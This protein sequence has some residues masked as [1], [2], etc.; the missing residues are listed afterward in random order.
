MSYTDP[1]ILKD[2]QN[3]D[4]RQRWASN[5]IKMVR[6]LLPPPYFARQIYFA[7]NGSG[8]HGQKLLA[9]ILKDLLVQKQFPPHIFMWNDQ[10]FS[11]NFMRVINKFPSNNPIVLPDPQ[12]I[13]QCAFENVLK[14]RD[15][16]PKIDDMGE[17]L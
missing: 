2:G 6:V 9:Q 16:T 10:N 15:G 8:V 12:R 17:Y 11:D 5:A 14:N 4:R 1:T 3:S 7:K 13:R